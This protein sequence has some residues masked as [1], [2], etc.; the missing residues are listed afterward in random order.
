MTRY[1]LRQNKRNKST[2]LQLE[3]NTLQLSPFTQSD[4]FLAPFATIPTH[5]NKKP[6]KA[7][8]TQRSQNSNAAEK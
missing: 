1:E 4:I 5:L 6:S 3:W 2:L 7:K 8:F